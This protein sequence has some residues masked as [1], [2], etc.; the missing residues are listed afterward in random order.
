MRF[1]EIDFLR[2][3]ALLMMIIYHLFYDVVFFGN[4]NF[5]L[6]SGILLLIARSSAAI[7]IFLV[8]VSLTISYSKARQ[9]QNFLKYLKRGLRIFSWGLLITL[10]T[11]F[12]LKRG[13]IVFGVLHFIGIAIILAY[14][15][16]KFR[17]RNILIGIVAIFL[18][19]YISAFNFDF[20][21]L[22][23]IG[24][25]PSNFYTFDYFPILPW[26]GVVLIGI[27]VGNM[28][29]P[30]A[31]RGFNI[32]EV[33]KS[34]IIKSFCFLGRHSLFIYLIHQPVIITLLYVFVL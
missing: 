8:G 13:V 18:G 31:K 30:N 29:Y 7:F 1:W 26:F 9:S 17:A 4:Y 14:P 11:W 6:H 27:F 12:F 21:W 32:P 19:F 20:P 3:I 22:L 23:W 15:F 16:V 33:S 28:V 25:A 5:N 24:I 34:R 2:G 10:A